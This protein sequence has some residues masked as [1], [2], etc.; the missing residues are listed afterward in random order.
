MSEF[1]RSFIAV[2]I[3]PDSAEEMSAAQQRLRAADASVKWVDP[4]GLHITLKFLGSV[5][6]ERLTDVWRSAEQA[7]NGSRAFTMRFQGVG[8]FPTLSRPRVIWAGVAEGA[9]ELADLAARVEAA[10]EKHGFERERRPFRG[11]VTLGRVRRPARNAALEA[12]LAAQAEAKLGEARVD[13][14]LLMKS[15]LTRAGAVY[16]ILEETLLSQGE[17]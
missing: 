14:T 5:E 4:K 9:E 3:P 8:A 11:H 17:S 15:E 1:I 2:K 12:A 7:L 13:R 6:R 16:H 10:C